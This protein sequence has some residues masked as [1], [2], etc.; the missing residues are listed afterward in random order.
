MSCCAAGQEEIDCAGFALA[1]RLFDQLDAWVA[2]HRLAD[3]W[4]GAIGAGAGDHDDL[5]DFDTVK[6]LVDQRI[7]QRSDIF[8]FVVGCDTHAADDGWISS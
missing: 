8:L 6:M 1:P 2:R 3:D 7:E 4:N 5:A